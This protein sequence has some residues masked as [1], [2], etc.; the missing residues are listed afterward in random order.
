[1]DEKNTWWAFRIERGVHI[2]KT[3]LN[4]QQ[5]AQE[6]NAGNVGKTDPDGF[7]WV[8]LLATEAGEL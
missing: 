3:R 8:A 6:F 2:P 7:Q 1:M 4:D 5:S